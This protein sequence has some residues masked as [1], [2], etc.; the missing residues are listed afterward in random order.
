MSQAS[1]QI[2][3]SL[4]AGEDL[5]DYQYHAVMIELG[6]SNTVIKAGTP[7]AEGTHVIGIL[8][9]EPEDGEAASVAIGGTSKLIM[10]ANCDAGEKL[11][12][13]SGKGTPVTTDNYSVIGIALEDNAEGDGGIIEVLLTPGGH[14]HANE[15]N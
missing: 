14:G 11:M 1:N 2:V 15:S 13:S 9:N 3:K 4:I 8:Q 6:T 12:S 10:A 5:S 7:A